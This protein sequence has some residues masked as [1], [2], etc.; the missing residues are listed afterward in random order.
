[1]TRSQI[2]SCILP[3]LFIILF[4]TGILLYVR[5]SSPLSFEKQM[6][7]FYAFLKRA[8]NIDDLDKDGRGL[9]I[10]VKDDLNNDGLI[11]FIVF[12]KRQGFCGSGGCT[13]YVYVRSEN[14]DY[15]NVLELLGHTTPRVEPR[16]IGKYNTISTLYYRSGDL[17]IW[18]IFKWEAKRY[19][20]SHYKFCGTVALEYCNDD[21]EDTVFISTDAVEGSDK[22]AMAA[23]IFAEPNSQ[24]KR[25]DIRP[26]V[27]VL[28]KVR[29]SDWYLVEIDW[30]G[31][32]GFVEGRY[33]NQ[34]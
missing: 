5:H 30:K 14:N 33:V 19:R 27:D 8:N 26:P 16:K 12:D 1:M 13:M 23:P 10:L 7:E 11:D 28:G 17:P 22:E 18:S 34:R 9:E 21:S 32:A 6:D 29:N 15:L 25:L 3:S 20:A 24:S 4:G 2:I 31:E